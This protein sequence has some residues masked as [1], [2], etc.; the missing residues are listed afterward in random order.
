MTGIIWYQDK[1]KSERAFNNILT[2]YENK[3]IKLVSIQRRKEY[4]QA[5]FENGDY[6]RTSS[7]IICS[8]GLACNIALIQKEI[9]EQIVHEVILPT[10]K[11]SPYKKYCYY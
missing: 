8:L 11:S 1:E 5:I 6:W 3:D 2:F 7:I 4:S 9:D 10:V